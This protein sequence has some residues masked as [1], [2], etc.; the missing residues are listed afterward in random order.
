MSKVPL[1]VVIVGTILTSCGA[2]QSVSSSSSS[3]SLAYE[4]PAHIDH[5]A[6]PPPSG[7]QSSTPQTA[8]SPS[9]GGTATYGPADSTPGD[10]MI[11]RTS[12]RW[13]AVNGNDRLE[14]SPVE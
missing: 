1:V 9:P 3:P 2:P 12:P 14:G 11:W 6:L 5:A 10:H 7:Y 8:N 13:T 4:P